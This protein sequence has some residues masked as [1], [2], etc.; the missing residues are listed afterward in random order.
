M[1]LLSALAIG[2][3]ITIAFYSLYYASKT[4]TGK[5]LPC[6]IAEISPDF[7]PAQRNQ[8]RLIRGHKL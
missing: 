2:F 5:T 4:T 1:K 8:C 7:T 3:Y 6:E